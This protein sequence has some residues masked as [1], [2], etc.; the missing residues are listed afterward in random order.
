MK[1]FILMMLMVPAVCFGQG[2]IFDP[3]ANSSDILRLSSV[4]PFF[5][6]AR[7]IDFSGI[8]TP[9][10]MVD[11][12]TP[13]VQAVEDKLF[14]GT[15]WSGEIYCTG[16]FSRVT[17]SNGSCSNYKLRSINACVNQNGEVIVRNIGVNLDD[18]ES[19]REVSRLIRNIPD[20]QEPAIYSDNRT[21]NKN[22]AGG[23]D[24]FIND[25]NV[26]AAQ[27]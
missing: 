20:Q 2:L 23:F 5:G 4:V 9:G 1:T 7:L 26:R 6:P 21:N 10:I 19:L 18:E 3:C 12:S 17:E 8:G 16:D 25:S 13:A 11:L 15:G 14:A 27:E 24:W 22:D